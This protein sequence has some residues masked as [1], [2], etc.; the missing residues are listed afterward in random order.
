M[1]KWL[2]N[3]DPD[4]RWI[5]RENLKKNRLVRMD[6]AWVARWRS[7]WATRFDKLSARNAR[8]LRCIPAQFEL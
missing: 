5:M 8:V 2:A 1:E 6:A 3:P 4:V 7:R